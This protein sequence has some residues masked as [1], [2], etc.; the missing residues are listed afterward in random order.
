MYKAILVFI[1]I[2]FNINS[3]FCNTVNEEYA[4]L[5]QSG[6]VPND[7]YANY[8]EKASLQRR[9][10]KCSAC[11]AYRVLRAVRRCDC[12]IGGNTYY[13]RESTAVIKIP[14]PPVHPGKPFNMPLMLPNPVT[15]FWCI[16]VNMTGFRLNG[17]EHQANTSPSRG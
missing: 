2:I 16:R 14:A 9:T 17:A 5:Y 4:G 3:S 1:F 12:S 6:S 13:V 10:E 7:S 15:P 8:S 11:V